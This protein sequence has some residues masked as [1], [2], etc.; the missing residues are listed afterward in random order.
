MLA[1]DSFQF[2][3]ERS[4]AE[5]YI[6]LLT[7]DKNTRVTF[8]AALPDEVWKA[9]NKDVNAKKPTARHFFGSLS[10]CFADL[11]KLNK[12]GWGIYCTVQETTSK[13]RKTENIGKVRACFVDIDVVG[14]QPN[15]HKPP[16][17]VVQSSKGKFHPYWV[18]STPEQLSK[19]DFKEYQQHLIKKYSGSDDCVHDL[20]R[21]MRLPGFFHTKGEPF[22]TEIIQVNN[23]AYT[24]NELFQEDITLNRQIEL[25]QQLLDAGVSPSEAI[26]AAK[27]ATSQ[28]K[29]LHAVPTV[30]DEYRTALVKKYRESIK[31]ISQ[32]KPGKRNSTITKECFTLG[33]FLAY[34]PDIKDAFIVE[35]SEALKTWGW[36]GND[37]TIE[38]VTRSLEDGAKKPLKLRNNPKIDDER[39][40]KHTK[41]KTRILKWLEDGEYSIEWNEMGMVLELNR[42]PIEIESLHQMFLD[43]SNIDCG[44][45]TFTDIATYIAKQAK[46]HPVLEYLESLPAEEKPEAIEQ[47]YQA[48]GVNDEFQ[49]KLI[50]KHLIASVGR[51]FSPGLKHD[52]VLI[53]KGKQ[54]SR[55]TTF[56]KTLYG[57]DFF[58]STMRHGKEA[59]EIMAMRFAWCNEMGEIETTFDYKS[60][61]EL[62][63]FITR[64]YDNF[65]APY[66]K[67]PMRHARNFINVGSTNKDEF[68]TDPTGNRRYWVIDISRVI[69]LETIAEI[70]DD[71]WS[72]AIALFKAGIPNQLN[73]EEEALQA[74]NVA[75]S[76]VQDLLTP[77]IINIIQHKADFTM[78]ELL[79]ELSMPLE[80]KNEMRIGKI[81]EMLGCTKERKIIPG[82]KGRKIYWKFHR[83]EIQAQE[84]VQEKVQEQ[85]QE[86]QE[87]QPQQPQEID[88]P[89]AIAENWNNFPK[90][91]E[92]LVLMPTPDFQEYLKI[93]NDEQTKRLKECRKYEN[94]ADIF[95]ADIDSECDDP[96]LDELIDGLLEE[97]E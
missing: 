68:L 51:I 39:V 92:I 64:E 41:L 82:T 8:M 36:D 89:K 32:L 10:E 49:R 24:V 80:R 91:H 85:P 78:L 56:F 96:A 23:L 33:G 55:K 37:K 44:K 77:Q 93:C 26:K 11:E 52:G 47:L 84:K 43:E 72:H 15:Y 27:E 81:L 46:Y 74:L 86:P 70:R 25:T 18:L 95:L 58:Q 50:I 48:M 76:E 9:K 83:Q 61:A 2:N 69:D 35:F 54:G 30:D 40:S 4:Q 6:E 60:V 1:Q 19:E 67:A 87:P 53:L 97:I 17:F 7:G 59:D 21:V 12:Q 16:S 90:L 57:V 94:I 75:N 62:K 29:H 45:E 66:A 79:T 5:L 71:I 14:N 31:K 13:S 28:E 88:F 20:A 73:Q 65:R 3:P 42:E 22:L 38:T 63:A 34:T